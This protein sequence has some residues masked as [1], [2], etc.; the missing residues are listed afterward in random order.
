MSRAYTNDGK[1]RSSQTHAKR[2]YECQVCG[3]K[4]RGNGALTSHKRKHV[5]E[6]TGPEL[7][8]RKYPADA[9]RREAMKAARP[10]KRCSSAASTCRFMADGE[11]G[12]CDYHRRTGPWRVGKP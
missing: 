6:G 1:R 11:D 9:K 12:L 10:R 4:L 5:R 8:D 3:E 2:V 7:W